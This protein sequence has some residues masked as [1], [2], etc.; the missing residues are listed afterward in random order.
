MYYLTEIAMKP[1]SKQLLDSKLLFSVQ[2]L[3]LYFRCRKTLLR[4]YIT[5]S[6]LLLCFISQGYA[7][8]S[9]P[10]NREIDN[11]TSVDP[12]KSLSLAKLALVDAQSNADVEQQLVA[13]FY[14][15]ESLFVLSDSVEIDAYIAK[16]LTLAEQSHNSRFISEFTGHQTY[17]QEVK[18]DYQAANVSANKALQLAQSIDDKRLIAVQ[19]AL[20]GQV[21]LAMEN[22]DMAMKDVDETT[23]KFIHLFFS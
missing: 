4:H 18:G 23:Q 2:V 22:Y 7:S 16:G 21:H 20:R 11:L 17:Q 13:I 5:I 8:Y 6:V 10:Y 12:N 3:Y 9:D 1:Y 14:I 19:T 15:V